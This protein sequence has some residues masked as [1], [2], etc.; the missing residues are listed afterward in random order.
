METR[1]FRELLSSGH[2]LSAK[3]I[4]REIEAIEGVRAL[5]YKPVFESEEK[6]TLHEHFLPAV[7]RG[8]DG[9]LVLDSRKTAKALDR[10]WARVRERGL[11]AAAVLT[12]SFV[13]RGMVVDSSGERVRFNPPYLYDLVDKSV[14]A[15]LRAGG[16]CLIPAVE[17]RVGN[18]ELVVLG[19][20]RESVFGN[21]RLWDREAIK[22]VGDLA[23][24]V[25]DDGRLVAFFPHPFLENG[26]AAHERNLGVDGTRR[27]MHEYGIGV[28]Y[29]GMFRELEIARRRLEPLLRVAG[30]V[31]AFGSTVGKIGETVA[32]TD[33]LPFLCEDAPS[34]SVGGDFHLPERHIGEAAMVVR[35]SRRARRL[36][37]DESYTV[38]EGPSGLVLLGASGRAMEE[39]GA[40]DSKSHTQEILDSLKGSSGRK[41]VLPGYDQS[42]FKTF[43][44]IAADMV[45]GHW[46][47][48]NTIFDGR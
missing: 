45:F 20:D 46:L 7:K 8:V 30:G 28:E 19:P 14:P 34:V 24:A 41:V 29:N 9:E 13:D 1:R 22:S 21:G 39:A 2:E 42:L 48:E 5:K 33:L 31:R 15:D 3:G 11:K 16:F 25:H 18:V 36:P 27:L 47:K 43:T 32:Q 38:S 37:L 23:K 17:F 10:M 40:V 12:H 4:L 6:V 26:G 44:V 35:V